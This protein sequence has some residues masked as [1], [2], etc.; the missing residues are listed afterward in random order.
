MEIWVANNDGSSQMQLT[1]FGG[2]LT[3]A[4]RWSPDGQ[5]IVFNSRP[6]LSGE[7]RARSMAPA[8]MRVKFWNLWLTGALSRLFAMEFTSSRTPDVT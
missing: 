5:H 1:H 7:F 2:P 8:A 4:A 3:G 6:L